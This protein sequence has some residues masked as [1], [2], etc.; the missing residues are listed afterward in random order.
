MCLESFSLNEL[1]AIGVELQKK[2]IQTGSV[3]DNEALANGWYA[4]FQ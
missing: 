3:I 4:R 2:S 1:F